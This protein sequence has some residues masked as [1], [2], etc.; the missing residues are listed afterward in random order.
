MHIFG[1]LLSFS[2]TGLNGKFI[3]GTVIH[4]IDGGQ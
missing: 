4:L 1:Q 2:V 3:L